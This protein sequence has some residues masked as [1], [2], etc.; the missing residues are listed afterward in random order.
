MFLV[1]FK[2]A[3]LPAPRSRSS[4]PSWLEGIGRGRPAILLGGAA[5]LLDS[6]ALRIAQ[7]QIV[8]GTNWTLRALVPTIWQVVDSPVYKHERANLNR[9]PDSMVILANAGIFGSKSPYSAAG[10]NAL[11]MVGNKKWP[12]YKI[13]I[14]SM[15]G[16]PGKIVDRKGLGIWHRNICEPYLPKK[17]TDEF[18]PGGNSLCFGIQTAHLMGCD[19]IYCLAFTLKPGTGYFHGLTNPVTKQRSNYDVVRALDW[20]QWYEG[21]FP[22]RVR[23]LPGWEGPVY[24]VF[25]TEALD[26]YRRVLGC[27]SL[28]VG[29]GASER[30][31]GAQRGDV[32]GEQRPGSDRAASAPGLW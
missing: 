19:P 12:I 30:D 27:G 13:S 22:R 2:A 18:H 16:K 8:I 24:D 11:R 6:A 26:D 7:G 31:A 28:A 23:L 21:S 1:D 32:H 9:C 25:A 3:Q 29:E 4:D 10:S 17:F 20:L 15:R 14:R 5:G